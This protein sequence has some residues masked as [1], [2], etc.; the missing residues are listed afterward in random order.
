MKESTQQR[1]ERF[2]A[3]RMENDKVGAATRNRYLAML[4]E[5]LTKE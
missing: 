1:I 4:K 2:L 5:C 3:E